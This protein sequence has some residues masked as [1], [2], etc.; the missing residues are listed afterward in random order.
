MATISSLSNQSSCEQSN[1]KKKEEKK[2]RIFDET[3]TKNIS[4]KF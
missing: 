4:A 3:N 1:F 2:R